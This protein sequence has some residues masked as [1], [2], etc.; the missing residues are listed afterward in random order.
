MV[1]FIRTAGQQNYDVIMLQELFIFKVLGFSMGDA[2][3][4]HVCHTLII[5]EFIYP[6]I[7][8]TRRV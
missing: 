2:L 3:R 7:L 4:D 6:S 1:H 5:C 8:G